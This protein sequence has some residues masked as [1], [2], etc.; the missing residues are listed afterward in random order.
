MNNSSDKRNKSDGEKKC[1][2]LKNKTLFFYDHE[3]IKIKALGGAKWIREQI[4][5]AKD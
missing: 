5:K 2:E 1:H 3:W 4:N